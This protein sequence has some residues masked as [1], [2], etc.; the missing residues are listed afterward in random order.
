MTPQ[1]WYD[2]MK[3][4]ISTKKVTLKATRFKDNA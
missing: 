4:I 1:Q 2:Y 3:Y